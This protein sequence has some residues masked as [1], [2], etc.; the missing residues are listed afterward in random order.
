MRFDVV[1]LFPE[2]FEAFASLGVV[3]RAIADERVSLRFQ[4]PRPFGQGKH[5][6]VDDTPYGG[7]AGMVMRV[8]CLVAAL[9]DLDASAPP[10]P[11]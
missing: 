4:S 1:T 10:G 5:K 6:N 2:M 9:E 8:D 11:V 7:G 3:G